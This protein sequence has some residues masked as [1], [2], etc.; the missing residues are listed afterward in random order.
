MQTDKK[1][2]ITDCVFGIIYLLQARGYI[3]VFVVRGANGAYLSLFVLVYSAVSLAYIYSRGAKPPK[4][5][6]FWFVVL[7]LCGVSFTLWSNEMMYFVPY[8]AVHLAAVYWTLTAADALVAGRSSAGFVY[9]GI[10]GFV[11]LPFRYFGSIVINIIAPFRRISIDKSRR[12]NAYMA[13]YGVFLVLPILCIVIPLLM[14]ASEE[15]ALMMRSISKWIPNM[16][17]KVNP[18]P[19]I[20]SVPVA[21]YLYG[22]ISGAIKSVPRDKA[23][24]EQ[25]A[26]APRVV[27]NVAVNTVICVLSGVYVL[28]FASQLGSMFAAFTGST[29]AGASLSDFAREGFFSLCGVAAINLIVLAAAAATAQKPWAADKLMR[30]GAVCI[31]LET[32]LLIVS[33][34]SKMWLYIAQKGL[35]PKRLF[36]TLFMLFLAFV[37]ILVIIRY[38]KRINITRIS[39]SVFCLGLALLLCVNAGG[40]IGRYNAFRIEAGTMDKTDIVKIYRM[41]GADGAASALSLLNSGVVEDNEELKYELEMYRSL[42][43]EIIRSG[44]FNWSWYTAGNLHF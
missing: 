35:T 34:V 9:D 7:Q 44:G 18:L 39:L 4:E 32:L 40:I 29:Y 42:A 17:F 19:F 30:V 14:N 1:R 33:A 27:A 5:S 36:T 3:E 10:R 8:L 43:P 26:N 13:L 2:T 24:I 28:F 37:F 41:L 16:F 15:F 31:S 22:L 25:S 6:W 20:L 12:K 38:K 11:L 23:A 21:M